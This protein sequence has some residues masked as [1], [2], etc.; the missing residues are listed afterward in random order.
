MIS[1]SIVPPEVPPAP[2]PV[3]PLDTVVEH[4]NINTWMP[5]EYEVEYDPEMF[6]A[7]LEA[8]EGGNE[9]YEGE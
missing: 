4:E 8:Y 1:S 5:E 7:Y 9:E 3:E 2:Q 6:E